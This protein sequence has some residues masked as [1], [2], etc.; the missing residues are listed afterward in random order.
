M[1][2]IAETIISAAQALPEGGLLSPREFLHLA[3]RAAVD[4]TFTRLVREGA[5]LRVGRGLYAAPIKGRF[6]LRPPATEAVVAA[7]E[8]TNGET[9]VASGA[10]EANGLGLTT[11]TPAREVF[12]TSGR[13]RTLQLGNRR[14][15]LRHGNKVQ[16]LLG[17]RPAGRAIRAL[18]WL[19]PERGAEAL[20]HLSGKLS[21]EE[22]RLMQSVRASMP[23]WMARAVSMEGGGVG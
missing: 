10:A 12:L 20:R 13:S 14:I 9:I 23:S 4:Q 11:Q 8:A 5:L 6:G 19:G 1:S 22:W 21:A 3:S 18:A 16:L 2:R 15:E 7:I 17:Q